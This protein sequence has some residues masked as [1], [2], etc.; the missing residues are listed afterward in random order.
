MSIHCS[1][2]SDDPV[3]KHKILVVIPTLNEAKHIKEVLQRLRQDLPTDAS[4][5]FAIVDGG[6]IDGTPDIV[7]HAFPNCDDIVVLHNP[8]RIQSAAVNLA[9]NLLGRK[10]D[11]LVR[12]DAHAVYP[13]GYIRELLET[14]QNINCDSV[15]VPMDSVGTCRVQTAVAWISDTKIGSGGSA[16]RGGRVSRFVDHGHHALFLIDSFRRAGGY[17]E[18]FTHNE[19]AEFDC[20]L[21]AIGGKIFLN[22]NIR[23]EYHPRSSFSS[24]WRQYY[25]YGKGRS[26]TAQRHPHSLKARQIAV[27][28]YLGLCLAFIPLSI[29]WP[30]LLAPTLIY[31]GI[32]AGASGTFSIRR[33]S[34]TGLLTGPSAFI[35]HTAWAS[36]FIV[37]LLTMRVTPWC[38]T[39]AVAT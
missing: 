39:G 19:D 38:R 8:R 26:R 20:R 34:V 32:L 30:F 36:G 14:C 4:I 28:A 3:K 37:G 24:L 1:R 16:H 25:L 7:R 2:E 9:V 31:L 15:V 27:P 29:W 18:S 23:I 6:S 35:M 22:G 21:R 13:I 11:F 17:D 33:W 5:C 10:A 12:V